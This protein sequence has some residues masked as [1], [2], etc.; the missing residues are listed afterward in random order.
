VERIF[1]DVGL[2]LL[3]KMNFIRFCAQHVFIHVVLDLF[4]HFGAERFYDFRGGAENEG[5]R[6]DDHAL[7]DHGIGADD[8]VFS[9][10]CVVEDGGVHANEDVVGEGGSVDD[11]GVTDYAVGPNGTGR[12]GVGMNHCIVLDIGSFADAN[13]VGIAS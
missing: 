11:C 9:N 1:V 12:S 5:I 13:G 4:F 10:L 3:I 6:R 8:A 7:G 2:I